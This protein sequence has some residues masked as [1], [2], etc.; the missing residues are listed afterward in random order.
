MSICAQCHKKLGWWRTKVAFEN[1][2]FC[3]EA[4]KDAYRKAIEKQLAEAK[5]E[6]EKQLAEAERKRRAREARKAREKEQKRI[7]EE[8]IRNLKKK[9][10]S[11]PQ[12]G[13]L[14]FELGELLDKLDE[15]GTNAEE[16]R[17]DAYLKA[18]T[19]G[20]PNSVQRGKAY[21]RLAWWG[22]HDLEE[23][24]PLRRQ[25]LE[26]AA[27][28]FRFALKSEP[29]NLE[30]LEELGRKKEQGEILAQAEE[31]KASRKLKLPASKPKPELAPFAK[32]VSF[33]EKCLQVIEA[34]GFKARMR[35]ITADSGIDIV[36]V[37]SQPLIAGTYIIQ[38]KNWSKPVGEP[39]LRDLYGV[40][41]SEL[42][43]KGILIATSGFTKAAQ[44][45]AKGKQLELIDGEQLDQLLQKYL[46]N[47]TN[48]E[49]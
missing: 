43:N 7:R 25:Y 1:R 27:R 10:A 13:V 44:D 32:G 6:A 11:E 18:V 38:C 45:F 3:S 14:C 16:R 41:A 24:S 31:V 4:C 29:D 21:H 5:T 42:A 47:E 12:N 26:N 39:V 20:L 46:R 30:V 37:S 35:Q 19:L 9:I 8:P 17:Y 40:V 2:E 34:M 15:H 33:Q 36:A 23:N 48:I 28:E 22:F 49:P